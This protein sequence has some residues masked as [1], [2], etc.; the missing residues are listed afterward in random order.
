LR[1]KL[2]R[3][4]GILICGSHEQVIGL[5][6]EH[7]EREKP[8]KIVTVGDQVSKDLS[9]HDLVP[10]ILIV[11][12]KIMRK[13]IEPVSA[14]ADKVVRVRN[15]PGTITDEA[16]SAI[17]RAAQGFERTKIVVKGEED[18]LA[19]VAIIA[20]PEDSVVIYGQPR[21]GIV[22]VRAT[23]EMKRLTREMVASMEER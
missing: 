23:P 17:D 21:R 12:N 15:P 10:D 14:A 18:L 4:L 5:L 16:W 8:Q 22:L 9:N 1:R 13:N 20:V 3:P 6:R 2:K 7:I 19:L 11:D